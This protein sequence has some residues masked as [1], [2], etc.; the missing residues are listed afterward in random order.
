MRTKHLGIPDSGPMAG[1]LNGVTGAAW[2]TPIAKVR[3][4]DRRGRAGL[5]VRA[6]PGAEQVRRAVEPDHA[7]GLAV[8]R[9]DPRPAGCP[10]IHRREPRSRSSRN[11]HG[12]DASRRSGRIGRW[13]QRRRNRLPPHAGDRRRR[14]WPQNMRRSAPGSAPPAPAGRLEENFA[15]A[16]ASDPLSRR[17]QLNHLQSPKS[18][19]GSSR[20]L[21]AQDEITM[22]AKYG[23]AVS[24]FCKLPTPL[25]TKG[26]R[27]GTQLGVAKF[28]SLRRLLEF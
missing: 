1:L 15:G 7:H 19:S 6:R 3:S 2:A 8:G 25:P 23:E 24:G 5:G 16:V 14:C 9:C 22:P 13:Y 18:R 21:A 20:F 27:G 28:Q 10:G 4:G 17:D 11:R 12:R 26:C